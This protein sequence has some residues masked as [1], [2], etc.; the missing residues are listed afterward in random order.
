MLTST[1]ILK[2]IENLENSKKGKMKFQAFVYYPER[3]PAYWKPELLEVW[4]K[5]HPAGKMLILTARS[6]RVHTE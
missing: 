5:S 3:N 4:K 6:F 1:S 2:R